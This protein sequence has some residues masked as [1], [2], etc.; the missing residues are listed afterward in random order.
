MLVGRPIALAHG[1]AHGSGGGAA[2][3]GAGQGDDGAAGLQRLGAKSHTH[4]P[5][6]P[7]LG[8][9]VFELALKHAVPGMNLRNVA[10]RGAGILFEL[11][12]DTPLHDSL[13]SSIRQSS[14][15]GKRTQT[16]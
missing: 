8:I 1:D 16:E 6:T 3:V 2:G 4:Q 7:T 13:P 12:T 14:R 9:G 10:N 5:S 15:M 11:Y